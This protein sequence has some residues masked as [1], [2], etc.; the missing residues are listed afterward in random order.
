V[1]KVIKRP[2]G[3]EEIV[4][5]TA[6]EIAEYERRLKEGGKL[7]PSSK[8]KPVLHGASVAVPNDKAY[9]FYDGNAEVPVSWKK[10]TSS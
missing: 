7:P 3:T 6:D 9:L 2:D 1:R 4:E 8:R 10:A 5:G